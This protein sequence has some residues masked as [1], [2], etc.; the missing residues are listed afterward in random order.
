M[1]CTDMAIRAMEWETEPGGS[2]DEH[3]HLGTGTGAAEKGRET[4][5]YVRASEPREERISGGSG[6]PHQRYE[7]SLK[8]AH[9]GLWLFYLRDPGGGVV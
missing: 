6:Q 2:S 8:D 5:G 9:G 4:Q 7:A 1:I 3:L